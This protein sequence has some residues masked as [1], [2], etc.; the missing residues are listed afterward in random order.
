M[1]KTTYTKTADTNGFPDRLRELAAEA[2][3]EAVWEHCVLPQERGLEQWMLN[4]INN[5]LV[6]NNCKVNAKYFRSL[7]SELHKD[8]NR[9]ENTFNEK[10]EH[11]SAFGYIYLFVWY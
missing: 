4:V 9:N 2:S 10:N 3:S 11:L 7:D 5:T 8:E 1:E 6:M